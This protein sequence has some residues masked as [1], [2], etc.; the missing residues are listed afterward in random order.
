MVYLVH[1]GYTVYHFGYA[2]EA[3]NF[4]ARWV[5]EFKEVR[6]WLEVINEEVRGVGKC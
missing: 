4:W 3:V 5:G 6:S 2:P 1:F